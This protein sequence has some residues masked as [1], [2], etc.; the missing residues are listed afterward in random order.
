MGSLGGGGLGAQ[1]ALALGH[2]FQISR[3]SWRTWVASQSAGTSEGGGGGWGK[4]MSAPRGGG[5]GAPCRTHGG[6]ELEAA[7]GHGLAFGGIAAGAA[8]GRGGRQLG[9]WTSASGAV[10]TRACPV[11][12]QGWSPRRGALFK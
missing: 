9:G 4:D 10:A 6:L 2:Y 8:G 12:L 3:V 7:A 1:G 5:T 11:S